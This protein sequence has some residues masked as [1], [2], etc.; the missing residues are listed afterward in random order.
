[1]ADPAELAGG[2]RGV[3]RLD[4]VEDAEDRT[5]RHA[6]A[7]RHLLRGGPQHAFAEEVEEGVDREVSAAVP[8]GPPAVRRGAGSGIGAVTS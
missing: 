4:V 6:G 2:R 7:L 3:E 8:A 1:M 5:Q